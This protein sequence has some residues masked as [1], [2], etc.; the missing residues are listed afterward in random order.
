MTEQLIKSHFDIFIEDKVDQFARS[1][2]FTKRKRK[3]TALNF[4]T[5][6]TYG[7]VSMKLPSLGGMVS[8]T[9]AQFTREALHYRFND[10][11]VSFL[12]KCFNHAMQQKVAS[13]PISTDLL[14]TYRQILIV[15]SSSW[16]VSPKLR[17]LLP[18]R[19]GDA[20]PANCKI[21]VGY[22]YKGGQL[23]FFKCDARHFSRQPIH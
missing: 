9:D 22:E 6:M 15:D 4:L 16:Y 17:H 7:L 8:V 2:G 23:A 10:S 12:Q 14:N 13:V 20:S 1:T 5:T 3:I 11:A 19:G 21:Q 18:G